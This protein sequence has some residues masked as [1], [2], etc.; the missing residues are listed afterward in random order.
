MIDVGWNRKPNIDSTKEEKQESSSSYLKPSDLH[1]VLNCVSLTTSISSPSWRGDG[2][3]ADEGGVKLSG[4][5]GSLALS[6]TF[7]D[8]LVEAT[9]FAGLVR[10]WC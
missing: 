2:Y 3:V 9:S 6:R 8:S 4:S 5:D 1:D 10:P 7:E